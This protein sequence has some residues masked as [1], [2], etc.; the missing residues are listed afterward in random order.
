MELLGKK[1][2]RFL[3][4]F[5]LLMFQINGAY[6]IEENF[7]EPQ[8]NAQTHLDE[9]QSAEEIQAEFDKIQSQL[10]GAKEEEANPFDTAVQEENQELQAQETAQEQVQ[11]KEPKANL[12][13][14][15]N[16]RKT[17]IH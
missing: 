10:E 3:L 13:S 12:G 1:V 9:V 14:L 17:I 2:Y 16:I 4:I 5:A 8:E 7:V 15:G 6:S 11:T